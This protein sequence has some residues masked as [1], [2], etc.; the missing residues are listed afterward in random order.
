MFTPPEKLQAI[1]TLNLPWNLKARWIFCTFAR[2]VCCQ[3]QHVPTFAQLMSL[4][5]SHC[6][7][8]ALE[9]GG[10]LPSSQ[11][12]PTKYLGPNNWTCIFYKPSPTNVKNNNQLVHILT[13]WWPLLNI[14]REQRYQ[15]RNDA[16]SKKHFKQKQ[17][18]KSNFEQL[19][20]WLQMF[21]QLLGFCAI[22]FVVPSWSRRAGLQHTDLLWAR[23]WRCDGIDH[24]RNW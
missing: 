6:T 12:I 1:L 20:L 8:E 11:L 18:V 15:V 4:A 10:W 14:W 24:M 3:F 17:F 9:S 13:S 21:A 5:S 23:P 2:F 16:F 19:L 7:T 22:D